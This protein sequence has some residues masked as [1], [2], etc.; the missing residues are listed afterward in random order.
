MRIT[1]LVREALTSAWAAK[2]PSILV[3]VVSAA[4][5]FVA[6]MT[7]GQTAASQAAVRANLET[8]GGR[9][10][11]V[12]DTTARAGFINARTIAAVAALNTT[13][14]AVGLA[15]PFD[16]TNGKIG[17]G[18][19]LVTT[20]PVH[21][22]LTTA[23]TLTRGRWPQPGEALISVT[24]KA[25]LGLEQP[26]GYLAAGT[27]QYPIVG[28]FSAAAPFD[29]FATGAVVN[30]NGTGTANELRVVLD[31]I[32]SAGSA[33]SAVLS[34]LAPAD[35][36]S[37]AVE[38]PRGLSDLTEA[39]GTQLAQSGRALLLLILG[40]GGVFVA[41]VVL[42][43]VM[44]RRRDLGRRRT[45]GAT[46]A[47]LTAMVTVRAAVPAAIGAA[48]GSLVAVAITTQGGF[49][50]PA[51]FAAAVAV[52]TTV[53]AAIAALLPAAYAARRDPVTVMRT[54]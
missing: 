2:V 31:A 42:A 11:I 39:L 14:A 10:L 23:V 19:T 9:T 21:G 24:A 26:L 30:A 25:R 32:S 12:R 15:M 38:S 17:R 51:D 8:A 49:P 5:C 48:L 4:M 34:I 3:A 53:T 54:P 41:A 1:G 33:Q 35:P 44:V 47:D 37:V 27:H 7:V 45:L 16:S 20:W 28:Q 29:D 22:D 43:D 6:L 36:A 13:R 52:L 40:V 50:P 46:R 18:G